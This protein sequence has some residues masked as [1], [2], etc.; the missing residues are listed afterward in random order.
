MAS[1]MGLLPLLILVALIFGVIFVVRKFSKKPLPE[2]PGP[3]GE[4]PYGVHGWLAFYVYASMTIGPLMSLGRTNSEFLSAESKYPHLLSLDIWGSYKTTIWIGSVLFLIWQIWV[5][6]QLNNKHVPRSVTHVKVLTIGAPIGMTIF[7]LVA[8]YA[9]LEAAPNEENFL[10]LFTGLITGGIWFAYFSRSKRVRNTY[11][12]ANGIDSQQN[13]SGAI[14]DSVPTSKSFSP[15]QLTKQSPTQSEEDHWAAAMDEVATGKQRPGL[16]A[17][18]FAEANG[19]ETKAKV[20]YLKTRVDQLIATEREQIAQKKTELL[21]DAIAEQS[22]LKELES[23]H[24][25]KIQ[26][27]EDLMRKH[28]ITRLHNGRFVVRQFV[29]IFKIIKDTEFDTL[30]EALVFCG[31]TISGE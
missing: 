2:G 6:L 27:E 16:W 7:L 19:D 23:A 15:G 13:S 22:K 9:I 26:S 8:Q 30:E 31:A 14:A 20:A 3:N 17:K 11:G 29:G 25:I 10:G 5:A 12:L 21:M 24:N 4:T 1:L 18:A 28:Q